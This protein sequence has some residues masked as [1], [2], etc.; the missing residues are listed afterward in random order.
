MNRS[1]LALTPEMLRRRLVKRGLS[2]TDVLEVLKRI[3]ERKKGLRRQRVHRLTVIEPWEAII[4]PLKREIGTVCAS[5]EYKRKRGNLAEREFL[6]NYL[7]LMRKLL[8]RF[9]RYQK[10]EHLTPKLAAE[11]KLGEGEPFTHWTH[12][13][14]DEIKRAFR[15]EHGQILHG[16]RGKRKEL[17]PFNY[18]CETES[19]RRF[20]LGLALR[21][22]VAENERMQ[23]L[24]PSN[25]HL[26]RC[27]EI[28]MMAYARVD[29]LQ[30]DQKAPRKWD[31]L[32]SRAERKELGMGR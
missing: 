30:P 1:Y 4:E 28:Y 13:V 8:E 29:A 18:I 16:K 25:E 5:M 9:R 6:A 15:A 24:M 27:H 12:W 10:A 21:K 32:L 11:K 23:K 19:N 20:R 22:Q 17:F 2:H 7:R 31:A 26:K 14:P 3:A